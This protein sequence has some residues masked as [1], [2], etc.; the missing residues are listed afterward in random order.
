MSFPKIVI[1][2]VIVLFS[3]ISIAT[4]VKKIKSK[5]EIVFDAK[6]KKIQEIVID[7]RNEKQP[8]KETKP[9]LKIQTDALAK[10]ETKNEEKKIL[11]SVKNETP[12]IVKNQTSQ[13]VKNE[14]HGAINN[15]ETRP[16]IKNEA[17]AALRQEK[18]V[19]E[20]S[21][22]NLPESNI[23]D[24]LFATDSSRLP[25]VETVVYNSR[26]PWQKG[27]PA[28]IADYAAHYSTT[29]HFIARSL[30]KKADYFTQKVSTGD[31]FNVLKEGKN[32]S[33]Y[34]LIDLN[35]SKL[36]FYYLDN[37]TNERT[38]LKTYK[39]GLGRKDSKHPSGT[40]TPAGKYSLGG[41]VAIYKPKI[42]G[43]FQDKKIEMIK[44]FGT[45]WIPFEQEIANCSEAS[46]GLGIHG[47][48]WI[49]SVNGELAEDRSKVGKFDSDG[50]VRL[51]SEDIE[52]IFAI[53]IS[54]PAII[55]LVKDFH[56]A[57]LPGIEKQY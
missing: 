3:S 57:K 42:L 13:S 33:F 9:K 7:E 17:S 30:N 23:I 50:C 44:V 48:P 10:K 39:V 15:N 51:Y 49:N 47:A 14:T 26:V 29:R 21:P 45:R 19:A 53:V 16:V 2:G 38:L 25:I 40:L 28:W 43:Y 31:R 11:A 6:Q 35:R 8:I 54:R 4:V 22:E 41:K 18:S 27:R 34:L 5:N 36:W 1:I 24:R 46:K 56:D 37:D 12:I 55:E 32:I 52:E 20:K